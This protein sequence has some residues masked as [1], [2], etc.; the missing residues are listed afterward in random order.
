MARRGE[1]V[2]GCR[3]V[4]FAECKAWAIEQPILRKEI[5][6]FNK[7]FDKKLNMAVLWV[8]EKPTDEL[9]ARYLG[10]TLDKGNRDR[11]DNF[12]AI[13][14]EENTVLFEIQ[15]KMFPVPPAIVEAAMARVVAEPMERTE[16]Q[17]ANDVLGV[18]AG[19]AR[20]SP[21]RREQHIKELDEFIAYLDDLN[22]ERDA[23]KRVEDNA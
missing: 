12:L 13:N 3:K 2:N 8:D 7:D 21:E 9:R 19:I 4:T 17:V 18:N 22:V 6:E 1:A 5:M 23:K 20:M 14:D 15:E 10:W 16:E 11:Y